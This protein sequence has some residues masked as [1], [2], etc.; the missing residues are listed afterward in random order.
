VSRFCDALPR[1]VRFKDGVQ[2]SQ[3]FAHAGG[4]GD[5]KGFAGRREVG[6]TYQDG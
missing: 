5:F 3:Q 4:H 2:D 1:L 6:A